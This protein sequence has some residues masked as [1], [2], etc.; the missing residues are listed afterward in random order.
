MNK[1]NKFTKTLVTTALGFVA[2]SSSVFA[3]GDPNS[4]QY[5]P[6]GIK[7]VLAQKVFFLTEELMYKV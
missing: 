2:F 1:I 7:R 5:D 3:E 4:P 6:L